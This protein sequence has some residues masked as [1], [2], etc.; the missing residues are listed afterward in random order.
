[1]LDLLGMIL[2]IMFLYFIPFIIACIRK[3]KNSI[4]I[5]CVNF[6]LGWTLIGWVGSLVWALI[7]LDKEN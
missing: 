2:F 1:M 6:F 5:F 3:H 4:P 7:N